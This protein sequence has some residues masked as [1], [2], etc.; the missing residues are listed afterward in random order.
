M[1]ITNTQM[2]TGTVHCVLL[3]RIARGPNVSFPRVSFPRAALAR[4]HCRCPPARARKQRARSESTRACQASECTESGVPSTDLTAAGPG[5]R[6]TCARRRARS[7]SARSARASQ[8]RKRTTNRAR[9]RLCTDGGGACNVRRRRHI[10]R[11]SCA[12]S[13]PRAR[14]PRAR[15]REGVAPRVRRARAPSPERGSRERALSPRE[16]QASECTESESGVP[17]TDPTA[18]PVP[19]FRGVE[20][21]R[22]DERVRASSTRTELRAA[23]CPAFLWPKNLGKVSKGRFCQ[24]TFYGHFLLA[25]NLGKVSKGRFFQEIFY[26]F[27]DASFQ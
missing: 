13:E 5:A 25:K 16:R 14:K 3:G 1:Y 10:A 27:T 20:R 17:S 22:K 2:H 12:R 18:V 21:A 4:V 24:E 23:P 9:I 6:G 11:P 8:S 26:I 15:A 19:A 7:S